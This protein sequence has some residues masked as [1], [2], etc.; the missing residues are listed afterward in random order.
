MIKFVR[1]FFWDS[2]L[3]LI[4]A[5][6]LFAWPAPLQA[7]GVAG[8]SV[9]EPIDLAPGKDVY[10]P[11]GFAANHLNHRLYVFGGMAAPDLVFNQ[12]ANPTYGLKVIDTSTN[13]VVTGIDLGL[14][15]FPTYV[16][17]FEPRDLAVDESQ[18]SGGNQVYV[19]GVGEYI[20]LRVIDGATNT[21]QTGQG[22]DIVLP[23]D[24]D[25][26]IVNPNN[27]KVYVVS[28]D[29]K[30]TV[31]DG[32][33]RSVVK[34][35]SPAIGL[36]THTLV[37]NPQANKVFVFGPQ[38]LAI[39]NSDDDTYTMINVAY[40]VKA[41][42]FDPNTGHVL[43]AASE[44]TSAVAL[45]ALDGINGT[46]LQKETNIPENIQALAIDAANHHLYLGQPVDESA[47]TTGEIAIYD[48]DI[49]GPVGESPFPPGAAKLIFDGVGFEASL[50][51]LDY[52][53]YS[54][55]TFS[56]TRTWSV[57]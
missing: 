55:R 29:G 52:D 21:N 49:L 3:R 31:V 13:T 12:P 14:Y 8:I 32:P 37:L 28:Y 33:N 25:Q 45:Y 46:Q 38:A 26:L 51:F 17:P 1:R 19:L 4:P 43:M 23:N 34:T 48:S 30:V 42:I 22:T 15:Q 54:E 16:H 47:N 6:I 11:L 7:A 40:F 41:G 39:I 57:R 56:N 50:Y 44:G 18:T 9:L 2:L 10:Q 36:N 24:G 53:F 27:H 20:C 35:L 5:A